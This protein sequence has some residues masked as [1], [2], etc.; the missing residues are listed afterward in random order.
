MNKNRRFK[1]RYREGNMP[2]DLGRPDFNLQKEIE[3]G[4]L[5]PGRMLD[6]GCG[7]GSDALWLAKKGFEVTGTDLSDIAIQTAKERAVNAGLQC[8]FYAL[9][10]QQ[11]PV[12]GAPFD[13]VYD[14]G[15]FH[16]FDSHYMRKKFAKHT[17]EH[18]KEGGLWL[19]LI[20]SAD[21]PPRDV[22]PPRR[23]LKDV[24]AAMEPYFEFLS[25]VAGQ[26]DSE[27]EVPPRVWI[28]LMRKRG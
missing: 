12:P 8:Q 23:S 3:K 26:F 18:L 10:F 25:A 16:S 15:C 9:D 21:D 13:C 2:W 14:R 22:G 20:G 24:V 4:S 19:S 11:Q 5:K 27:R 28:C 1:Q 17:A 7:T 6:I